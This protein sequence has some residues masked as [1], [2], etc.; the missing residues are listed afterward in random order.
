[1]RNDKRRL[2]QMV[3]LYLSLFLF[4]GVFLLGC[5]DVKEK[6]D[7]KE[8][9]AFG[10]IGQSEWIERSKNNDFQLLIKAI[11]DKQCIAI[12]NVHFTLFDKY[13]FEIAG[14]PLQLIDS[15]DNEINYNCNCSFVDSDHDRF[16]SIGDRFIIKSTDHVNDDGNPSP[17]PCEEQCTFII[18]DV[19]WDMTIE[20]T[21]VK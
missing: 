16:L 13:G 10:W 5:I 11:D 15:H 12:K 2:N 3:T 14:G 17:G 21:I 19:K 7:E 6:N 18:E 4:L 1:M 20:E 8:E 9:Y